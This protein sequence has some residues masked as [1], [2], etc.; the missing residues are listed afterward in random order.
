LRLEPPYTTFSGV[1]SAC[2]II[3]HFLSRIIL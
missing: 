1:H 2:R 3:L